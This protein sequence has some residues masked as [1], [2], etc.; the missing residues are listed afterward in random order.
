MDFEEAINSIL[1]LFGFNRAEEAEEV[2]T[3]PPALHSEEQRQLQYQLGV[4]EL[5]AVIFNA[6]MT[7]EN[8][9][10]ELGARY[11]DKYRTKY[12]KG[13]A[14]LMFQPDYYAVSYTHLT[15][16]TKA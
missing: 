9:Q 2:G 7:R 1:G 16:P 11:M 13:L 12:P 4:Y 5:L 15:L 6:Q 8:P 14:T 10:I 3:T